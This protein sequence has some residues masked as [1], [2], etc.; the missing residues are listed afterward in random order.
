[1]PKLCSAASA[2]NLH[3]PS[4]APKTAAVKEVALSSAAHTRSAFAADS[5]SGA[6]RASLLVAESAPVAAEVKTGISASLCRDCGL[7]RGR[8][9]GRVRSRR[10]VLCR[11]RVLGRVVGRVVGRRSLRPRF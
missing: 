4:R 6:E 7:G 5:V 1:M 10:R 9:V 2:S 3:K 8:V 11:G